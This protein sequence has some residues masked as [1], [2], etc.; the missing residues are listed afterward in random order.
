M[1]DP[2]QMYLAAFSG[3][4]SS[5]T[6]SDAYESVFAQ[7]DKVVQLDF[8]AT[9]DRVPKHRKYNTE[10]INNRFMLPRVLE[11]SFR[12]HS[13][14]SLPSAVPD[15]ALG[16]TLGCSNGRRRV[17]TLMT[18]PW[19][20][21]EFAEDLYKA[22]PVPKDD[23]AFDWSDCIS[24]DILLLR[25]LLPTVFAIVHARGDNVGLL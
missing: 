14:K 16:E 7:P 1:M 5:D 23:P 8:Y 12:V 18:T 24:R 10:I 2:R 19:R 4:E 20:L 6:D 15:L 22:T 11:H 3:T 17:D 25:L 21:T 13:V 9:G